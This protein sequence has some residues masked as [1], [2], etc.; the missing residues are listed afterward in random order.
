ML[1]FPVVIRP[2]L[3]S[4]IAVLAANAAAAVFPGGQP[5]PL[6]E[7]AMEGAGFIKAQQR[8]DGVDLQL[9]PAQQA[10]RGGAARSEERRVGKEGG[11]R[12]EPEPR[13]QKR[14]K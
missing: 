4:P 7:G 14:D 12:A 5:G 3:W 2:V 13:R 9:G 11:C 8:R 10:H 1:P 6:L